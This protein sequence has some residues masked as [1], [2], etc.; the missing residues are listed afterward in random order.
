MDLIRLCRT[1][2]IQNLRSKQF[3]LEHAEPPL[4]IFVTRKNDL[5]YAY[6]NH[7]PHTGVNLNWREDQFLDIEQQFFQCALHGAL[8]QVENGYC[9]R[10]P[11]V[12]ESLQTVDITIKDDILY[13]Q[14]ER[15]PSE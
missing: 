12:G 1:D 5:F 11:C 13:Y 3:T 10:G 2:E 7:C 9:L 4:E 14:G 6:V 8:F 15:Q